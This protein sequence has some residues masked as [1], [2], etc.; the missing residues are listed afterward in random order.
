MTVRR[1]ENSGT[2]APAQR[3]TDITDGTSNT[4]SF[5]E[6]AA[7]PFSKDVFESSPANAN[8][9]CTNEVITGGAVESPKDPLG[10]LKSQDG[11]GVEMPP[12][13]KSF[14]DYTD[15]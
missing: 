15:D 6:M 8:S 7:K 9:L 3:L 10:R 5:A 13:K 11:V 2:S 1:A 4:L 12:A 14:M